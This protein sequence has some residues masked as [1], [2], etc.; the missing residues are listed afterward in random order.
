MPHPPA[1]DDACMPAPAAP[2]RSPDADAD[3]LARQLRHQVGQAIADFGMIEDGDT[4][5]V[6]LS[7]G[8]G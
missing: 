6:C 3:R 4:M 2:A 5:M 7:G 1:Y 8:K